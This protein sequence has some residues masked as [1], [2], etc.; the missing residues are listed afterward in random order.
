M[1]V[2]KKEILD[3]TVRYLGGGPG[4]NNDERE[5]L[6]FALCTESEAAGGVGAEA[7]RIM[8]AR[9]A[10]QQQARRMRHA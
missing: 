1:V 6:L 9:L 4:L 8:N 10:T 2:G 3:L 7:L 5:I